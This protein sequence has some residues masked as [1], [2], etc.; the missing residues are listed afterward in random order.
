[1]AIRDALGI[2]VIG[3][4]LL[5]G[6]ARDR[7]LPHVIERLAPRG[8]RLA[9]C[10]ILG[11][12]LESLAVQLRE[13][14]AGGVPVICFGGIGGTPDDC[15]RAA[16]AR[17][18]D[19]RLTRHPGAAREIAAQFGAAA[20]PQ[21]I[22]MADLPAG[23]RLIPNSYNRVPGFTLDHHHFLPGFPEMA[24]PMLERVLE[25]EFPDRLA[26]QR[27]RSVRL[28]GVREGDLVEVMEELAGAYPGCRLF[29][30]P[31]L[32]DRPFVE[33][34]FRGGGAVEEALA[35]LLAALRDRG[36]RFDPADGPE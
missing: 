32:G 12:E 24:W 18:F 20:Y 11:D 25:A 14:R 4:E 1:M 5:T 29:S 13:T 30:L 19:T 2:V 33:V 17:A 34:G 6:K 28:L 22:R 7:H 36:I 3:D 26:P 27:E 31:H 15:T 21:R 16:A 10:R 9:W 35:A 8:L 23:C